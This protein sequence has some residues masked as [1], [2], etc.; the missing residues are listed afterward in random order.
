LLLQTKDKI[1]TWRPGVKKVPK[2]NLKIILM[3]GRVC[4]LGAALAIYS[5]KKG[6]I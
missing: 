4:D 6:L 3:T 1:F 2:V 5:Q